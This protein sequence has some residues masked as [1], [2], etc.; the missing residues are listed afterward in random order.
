M[1]FFL[2]YSLFQAP[3]EGYLIDIIDSDWRL[4]KLPD[5][6]IALPLDKLPDLDT[7]TD[8]SSLKEQV[9]C[10]GQIFSVFWYLVGQEMFIVKSFWINFGLILIQRISFNFLG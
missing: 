7:D 8:Q 5:D 1:K 2:V 3:S 4:D 6:E 10:F 9:S